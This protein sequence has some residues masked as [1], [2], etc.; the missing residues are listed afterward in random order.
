MI[1]YVAGLHMHLLKCNE[2][3]VF[4]LLNAIPIM[5]FMILF[6]LEIPFHRTDSPSSC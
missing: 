5:D 2:A 1:N 4:C 6:I 3:G